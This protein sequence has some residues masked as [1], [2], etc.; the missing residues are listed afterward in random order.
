MQVPHCRKGERAE[1]KHGSDFHRVS[2]ITPWMLRLDSL[3]SRVGSFA[4]L[5]ILAMAMLLAAVLTACSV[6]PGDQQGT[7]DAWAARDAERAAEC[8]RKNVG[9]AAGGCVAS[10]P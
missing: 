9:Y 7:R 5:A 2:W 10:G 1:R 4:A 3:G 6:S 8:R